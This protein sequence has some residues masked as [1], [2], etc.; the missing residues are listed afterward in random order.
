MLKDI[1]TGDC[2]FTSVFIDNSHLFGGPFGLDMPLRPKSQYFDARIYV[3]PGSELKALLLERLKRF[4]AEKVHRSILSCPEEWKTTSG[5]TAVRHALHRLS[6]FEL[7]KTTF[8]QLIE[9]F[10]R[11]QEQPG[12]VPGDRRPKNSARENRSSLEFDPPRKTLPQEVGN[13]GLRG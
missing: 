8:E 11:C 5:L 3:H 6:S 9:I 13:I 7:V 1:Q 2:N 4:D 10:E 12:R